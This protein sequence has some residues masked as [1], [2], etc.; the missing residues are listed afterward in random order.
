M[1][2][3]FAGNCGIDRR[4]GP[5]RKR[6]FRFLKS[7]SLAGERGGHQ[8]DSDATHGKK[9]GGLISNASD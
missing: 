3:I 4:P 9:T 7:P 5:L 2:I 8:R 1:R 6:W